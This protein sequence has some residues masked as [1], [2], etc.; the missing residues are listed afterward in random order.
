MIIYDDK[1]Y[2]LDEVKTSIFLVITQKC[3][4]RCKYC[5]ESL[6]YPNN[7]M[8]WDNLKKIL[9]IIKDIPKLD[10][11]FFGGEPTLEYEKIDYVINQLKDRATYSII[12]NGYKIE[13]LIP[14]FKKWQEYGS[15]LQVSYD[16]EPLQSKNRIDAKI[17]L[18]N[19]KKLAQEN[20]DFSIKS[21]IPINDLI[22][23]KQV[24]FDF[25]KT[26]QELLEINPNTSISLSETIAQ[27][28]KENDITNIIP[29]FREQ[30]QDI[31]QDALKRDKPRFS[32]FQQAKVFC[33][34]GDNFISIDYNGDVYLCQHFLF[35]K[36]HCI[37]NIFNTPLSSLLRKKPWSGKIP[38]ECKSCSVCYCSPCSANSFFLSKKE[39]FNDR[40]LDYSVDKSRCN[41]NKIISEYSYAYKKLK[42]ERLNGI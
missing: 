29:T 1:K 26:R 10:L 35:N 13:H 5:Y 17:I 14:Y 40:I 33:S 3:N 37:G 24:Y 30:M 31:V 36:E 28:N 21:T 42:K 22:H 39:N 27:S 34:I 12:T 8:S 2:I 16:F 20:I 41:I 11:T 6:N 4:L 19:I 25:Q 18:E 7:A 32:F 15:S 9:F 38:K 23:I